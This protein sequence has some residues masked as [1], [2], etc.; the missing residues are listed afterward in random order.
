L[1]FGSVRII[2]DV[3]TLEGWMIAS[4][5]DEERYWTMP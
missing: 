4:S 3:D 2:M 1:P 5:Y